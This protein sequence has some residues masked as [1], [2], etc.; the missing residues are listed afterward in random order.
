M[1]G[2]ATLDSAERFTRLLVGC[3]RAKRFTDSCADGRNGHSPLELAGVDLAGADWL[4]FLL[5]R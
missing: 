5:D 3:Y 2:F 1:E 4:D